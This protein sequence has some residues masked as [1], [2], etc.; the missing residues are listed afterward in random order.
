MGC[1]YRIL[2]WHQ[3]RI[4][5]V[6]LPQLSLVVSYVQP[7]P[8]GF[9]VVG[10]R[11]RWHPEGAEPNAVVADF[12]G[13]ILRELTLGDGIEDVMV[14]RNGTIWVSYFDEGVFGNFGWGGPGPT[15]IGAS[16][17]VAFTPTGDLRFSYDPAAAGTDQICDAYAM[18][19]AANDDVW[20]YFYDE[21]PVIR[22]ANGNYQ[23]W[24]FGIGGAHG[25]AVHGTRVLLVGD[26]NRPSLGRVLHLGNDGVAHLVE[27]VL[28]VDDSGNPIEGARM[29]GLGSDLYFFKDTKVWIIRTW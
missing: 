14:S 4:D 10:A 7:L 16:G 17:L 23:K 26:Y 12:S 1:E 6:R 22:I 3:D 28:I 11:C 8:E 15:P 27:E 25:L 24:S 18:N 2:C 5:W 21:F 29:S 20:V 13:R 19:V 9:L